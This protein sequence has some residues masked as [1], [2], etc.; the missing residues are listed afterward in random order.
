MANGTKNYFRHSFF[1]AE[2]AKV[3]FVIDTMGYEGYGFY[4]SL[5]ELCGR[6]C[7][8]EVVN[9]V[10]FHIQTIRKV[11]RKNTESTEKVL[12]KLGESGLFVVTFSEHLVSLDIPNFSKYLGK[13][14][15]K[16]CNKSKVK[17][18]KVKE[19]KVKEKPVEKI[20]HS[21]NISPLGILFDT[22]HD[23][24]AWLKSGTESLQK[25]LLDKYEISYLTS[26]VLKAYY[27]QIE[28]K[29]RK[30]GSFLAQWL[31]RDKSAVINFT[32][33]PL[34]KFFIES[35]AKPLEALK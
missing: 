28:N 13:Y 34:Y 23:I 26:Q 2:D 30:A 22:E 33:D 14:E 10:V 5:L 11:W 27:W 7:A 4:F 29:K 32:H 31:D 24:Q 9:P 8:D 12:R 1:A 21:I 17:E 35:G 20:N 16:Y 25:Q 19:S 6:T 18:S 15:T 3:Q